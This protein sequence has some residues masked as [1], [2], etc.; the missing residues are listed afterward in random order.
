VLSASEGAKSV[1]EH[2]LWTAQSG[3]ETRRRNLRRIRRKQMRKVRTY[4]Y[5][6]RMLKVRLRRRI[7]NENQ[8]VL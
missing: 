5:A 7:R 4:S 1:E 2:K 8:R 3:K 6:A